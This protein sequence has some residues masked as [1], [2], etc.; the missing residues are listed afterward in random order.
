MHGYGICT[1]A[2][3]DRYEG[4][5][6]ASKIEGIG[7]TR[8]TRCDR[9]RCCKPTLRVGGDRD[10]LRLCICSRFAG[11]PRSLCCLAHIYSPTSPC[12]SRSLSRARTRRLL[13]REWRT[14]RGS[15]EQRPS[16]GERHM[17]L[18]ARRQTR[19]QMGGSQA[20]WGRSVWI[21]RACQ[22]S[23]ALSRTL[24]SRFSSFSRLALLSGRRHLLQ[25][26][27]IVFHR[28]VGE[29]SVGSED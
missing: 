7:Q 25:Q 17:V 4:E 20:A 28:R 5:Y 22:H 21:A 18:C 12:F 27:Q 29:G 6:H 19:W 24:S 16:E 9:Q 1:F 26:R 2:N 8:C 3:G 14:I 15:A 10:S 13:L 11:A 23:S